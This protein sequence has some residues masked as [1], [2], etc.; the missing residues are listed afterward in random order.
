MKRLLGEYG[1]DEVVSPAVWMISGG[2]TDIGAEL[3]GCTG[4]LTSRPSAIAR[5]GAIDDAHLPVFQTA[6]T[7]STLPA[8]APTSVV[9]TSPT[10]RSTS[11]LTVVRLTLEGGGIAVE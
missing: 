5:A 11:R 7:P 8:L 10:Q 2:G 6:L 9:S 3:S 1:E 4:E